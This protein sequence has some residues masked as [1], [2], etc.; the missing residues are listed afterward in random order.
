[1]RCA[2]IEHG[3]DNIRLLALSPG[4]TDTALADA[5][6]PPNLT[7]AEWAAL[8]AQFAMTNVDGLKRMA[9]P[10]EMATAALALASAD[11]SFLTGTSVLVD[12]GMLAGV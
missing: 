9:R 12:G 5:L 11:M 6:R 7:D 2:A 1:V 8:K 3:T 4:L 10:E